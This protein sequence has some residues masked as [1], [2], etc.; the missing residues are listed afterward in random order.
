MNEEV[1]GIAVAHTRKDV[2]RHLDLC[3]DC[4]TQYLL[5]LQTVLDETQGKVG[6]PALI[7]RPNLSF[8][9][10]PPLSQIARQ[11]AEHILTHL[12]PHQVPNLALVAEPFFA[13]LAAVGGALN[14]ERAY[15]PT[16]SSE[17]IEAFQVLVF[18]YYTSKALQSQQAADAAD[19]K[20][21]RLQARHSP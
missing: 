16:L 7:P 9:P 8:L 11:I 10:S 12:A 14:L 2:K 20:T 5:L 15:K 21:R 6:R 3:A 19:W 4:S 13:R 17:P 1:A 18:A